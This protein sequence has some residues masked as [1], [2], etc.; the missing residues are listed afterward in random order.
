MGEA[1]GKLGEASYFWGKH[2][3]CVLKKCGKMGEAIDSSTF[4]IILKG[5]KGVGGGRRGPYVAERS[6]LEFYQ[7][8]AGSW[9]RGDSM[10]SS[11]ELECMFQ[12]ARGDT[13]TSSVGSGEGPRIMILGSKTGVQQFWVGFGPV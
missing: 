12:R 8:W 2:A 11:D 10:N 4:F 5:G 9:T 3:F 7:Q 6:L 1:G 13:M